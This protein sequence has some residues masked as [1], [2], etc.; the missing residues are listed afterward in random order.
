MHVAEQRCWWQRVVPEAMYRRQCAAKE[1]GRGTRGVLST[2]A[3]RREDSTTMMEFEIIEQRYVSPSA[4][5]KWV[6]KRRAQHPTVVLALDD[7]IRRR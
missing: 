2:H 5:H 6:D 7:A 1:L 3:W 4:C